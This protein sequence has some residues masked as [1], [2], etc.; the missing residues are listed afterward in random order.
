MTEE[1]ISFH[2]IMERII[3]ISD[4]SQI[5]VKSIDDDWM[6]LYH[7]AHNLASSMENNGY[8]IKT[9][10]GGE[11]FNQEYLSRVIEL[12]GCYQ[13]VLEQDDSDSECSNTD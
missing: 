10:D 7:R 9:D 3:A 5:R 8:G 12:E 1:P 2:Q 13:S 4:K 6:I 11:K